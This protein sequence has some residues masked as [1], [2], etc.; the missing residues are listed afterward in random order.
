MVVSNP[1]WVP[2]SQ[3]D[4]D[5]VLQQVARILAHPVF[6]NSV[7]SAKVLQ[8]C[9]EQSLHA[10]GQHLKERTLGIEVFGRNAEYDTNQDTI[11]RAAASD[12][13]RRIAQYYHEPGHETELVIDLPPFAYA[14]EFH[15]PHGAPVAQESPTLQAETSAKPLR[16]FSISRGKLLVATSVLVA[17]ILAVIA[18]RMIWRTEGVK[19]Q[20]MT[21]AGTSS[22][23]NPAGTLLDSFWQPVLERS[24]TVLLCTG[25]TQMD[26]RGIG[27]ALA[28]PNFGPR[29][30]V[31]IAQLAKF[32]GRRGK[33]ILVKESNSTNASDMG[34]APAILISGQTNFWTLRETDPLRFHFAGGPEAGAVWIEDRENPSQRQWSI[35]LPGT[36]ATTDYAIAARL[37]DSTTG[38]WVVVAAGL[39]ENGTSA[40]AHCLIDTSCLNEILKSSPKD[41]ATKNVE[42]VIRTDVWSD[43]PNA[44]Q[45]MAVNF[46]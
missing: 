29:N 46:W 8:Y 36:T 1:P 3:A 42:W 35:A 43:A 9:V 15:L 22:R 21:A 17:V 45:V 19:S 28:K 25:E 33:S 6:R 27:T 4:R 7:R 26:T 20:R 24:G 41:W 2:K 38:N 14:P 16:A 30:A 11:V 40:A 5:A 31:A 10:N 44:P 23:Q 34:Q 37:L 13:R 18:A 39:G 32:L 12:V